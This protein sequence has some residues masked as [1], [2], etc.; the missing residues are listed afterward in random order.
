MVGGDDEAARQAG[1][2]TGLQ[3]PANFVRLGP[4]GQKA[5]LIQNVPH[6]GGKKREG[7]EE[8]ERK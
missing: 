3:I 8:R 2:V 7:S 6:L 5:V 4:N 1:K